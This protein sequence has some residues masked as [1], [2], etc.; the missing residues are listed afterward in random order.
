VILVVQR[1]GMVMVV[2]VGAGLIHRMG[3]DPPAG[4]TRG[5]FLARSWTVLEKLVKLVEG[6]RREQGEIQHHEQS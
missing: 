6:R 4:L 2:G 5:A 3:E 1:A